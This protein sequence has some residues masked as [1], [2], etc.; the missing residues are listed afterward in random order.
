MDKGYASQEININ[1]HKGSYL[2][3]R[4]EQII[5]YASSRFYQ[6]VN[7]KVEAN[8]TAVYCE[9][10]AA[11]RMA[12]GEMFDFDIC[13]LQMA[14]YDERDN[15]IFA[16]T[17]NIQPDKFRKYIRYAFGY[18]TILLNLYIITKTIDY[19]KLDQSITKVIKDQSIFGS[20][21][22]LPNEYGMVIRMLSDSV[23]EIKR[24]AGSVSSVVRGFLF[25]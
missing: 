8:S 1:M 4:P 9:I 22:A 14:A 24:F 20:C 11:G 17:L 3:F 23:D 12:S 13:F 2:E 21:S 25:A 10:L 16:D 15:I 18:K 19:K 6:P 5:P 7:L